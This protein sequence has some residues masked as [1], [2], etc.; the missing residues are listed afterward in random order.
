MDKKAEAGEMR[1]IVLEGAG[2]GRRA[3]VATRAVVAATIEAFSA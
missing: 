3:G 1:F 2:R